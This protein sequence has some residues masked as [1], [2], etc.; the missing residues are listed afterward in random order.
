MHLLAKENASIPKPSIPTYLYR[1]SF[2]LSSFFLFSVHR[3][4]SVDRTNGMSDIHMP[5][6]HHYVPTAAVA[7]AKTHFEN[8]RVVILDALPVRPSVC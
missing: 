8:G 6:S 7:V 4:P 5:D 3:P 1:L 2:F